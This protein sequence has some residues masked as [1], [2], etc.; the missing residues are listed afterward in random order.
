MLKNRNRVDTFRSL[1]RT[2]VEPVELSAEAQSSPDER[3]SSRRTPRP[4]TLERTPAMRLCFLTNHYPPHS[5]GSYDRQCWQIAGELARRNHQIDILTSKPPPGIHPGGT[6]PRVFRVLD[7][8]PES[9]DPSPSFKRLYGFVSSTRK[10]FAK[11]LA[12]SPPDA[13]MMWGMDRLPATLLQQAEASGI[14]CL[15]AVYNHWLANLRQR[16]PW[17]RFWEEEDTDTP[18]VRGILRGL[19]LDRYVTNRAAPGF[20]DTLSL[21]NVY[22]CS[23][24][25]RAETEKSSGLTLCGASIIPCGISPI[26]RPRKHDRNSS[27]FR[28]VYHA[29]LTPDKDPMTALRALRELRHRHG[30]RFTLDIYGRGSLDYETTL[31][32]FVRRYKLGGSVLFKT[33]YGPPAWEA[34]GIYDA[35]VFTSRHPEPFPLIHLHAM[36]AEI[37]V[38]STLCGAS[39]ELIRNGDNGLVFDAGNHHQLAERILEIADNP[40][41]ASRLTGTA[42]QEVY[43]NYGMGTVATQI[44]TSLLRMISEVRSGG[45]AV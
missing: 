43:R 8:Y 30:D 20:P 44:E 2:A 16:D 35:L 12:N 7:L 45:K 1:P 13:I 15:L 9:D 25:L 27:E 3:N 18:T 37:P 26:D 5:Q 10:I 34:L 17:I 31:H 4:T 11:H 28:L 21:R 14:P 32:D 42:R 41:L 19:R 23:A 22:F 33:L 39:A 6:E 36:A 38:I 24:S 29:R 40:D